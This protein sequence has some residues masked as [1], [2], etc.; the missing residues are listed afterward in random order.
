MMR[1]D[2]ARRFDGKKGWISN[3]TK[4][5]TNKIYSYYFQ[6]VDEEPD[7]WN[8]SNEKGR[9]TGILNYI[10]YIW[11]FKYYYHG[12]LYD[13]YEE[14]SYEPSE[15]ATLAAF[16]LHLVSKEED[17]SLPFYAIFERNK[18]KRKV[19]DWYL[20]SIII[21]DGN[22][23]YENKL[24]LSDDKSLSPGHLIRTKFPSHFVFTWFNSSHFFDNRMRLPMDIRTRIHNTKEISDT[25][26]KS[27]FDE[28]S[29][30]DDGYYH[31][32]NGDSEKNT[33]KDF[34]PHLLIEKWYAK[35]PKGGTP[36][37]LL[38]PNT[39]SFLYPLFIDDELIPEASLVF[40]ETLKTEQKIH[41]SGKTIYSLRQ[42]YRNAILLRGLHGMEN[43]WLSKTAVENSIKKDC[44]DKVPD[45]KVDTENKF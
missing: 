18:D 23:E 25:I 8:F 4:D 7:D 13:M 40:E 2:K 38:N 28:Y 39:D 27:L 20:K 31:Y 16:N 17:G 35:A 9:Y 3:S 33:V 19:S 24:T 32:I 14:N 45:A 41:I 43:T 34:K 10:R 21:N 29:M 15:D 12:I 37:T 11:K 5:L 22:S 1:K 26:L 36:D 30:G 44:K 6:H 42:A